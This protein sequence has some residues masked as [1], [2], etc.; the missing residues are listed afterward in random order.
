MYASLRRLPHPPGYLHRFLVLACLACVGLLAAPA[1]A[2]ADE[3]AD[4][5]QPT[6]AIPAERTAT[7][8]VD[9]VRI[10]MKG[11][12]LTVFHGTKI[13]PFP[14]EVVS[15]AHNAGP[16]RS[17]I[18]IRS[19]D[20]RLVKAGPVQGMSGSPIYLWEQDE[21]GEPGE[22]GRLIGA[23]AYGFSLSKECLA[24][25]QPIDYM[26]A[27]GQRA[28]EQPALP[29]RK[30]VDAGGGRVTGVAAAQRALAQMA[31]QRETEAE[32]P[33]LDAWR[34]LIDPARL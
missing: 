14:V 15:I 16:Q 4:G 5:E 17:V 12:G 13:E 21:T 7:M 29:P 25:V 26:R 22:G 10:G 11:Y 30:R 18:W 19:E 2:Q 31:A 34:A 27:V 23:F 9:E 20:P 6:R 32:A 1:T 28:A 33:H 8:P 3:P 24:G